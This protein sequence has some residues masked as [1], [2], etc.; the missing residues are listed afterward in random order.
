MDSMERRDQ[1]IAMLQSAQGAITGTELSQRCGVSRQVI[2]G[3]IAILRAQGQPIVSTPRGYQ[4]AGAASSGIQR[5]FVC[6]HG[7][8]QMRAELE[9]IV[10]NGGIVRNVVIEHEIY[11]NLEGTLNLHSRRDVQQFICKIENSPDDLLSSISGGI[12]T[13]LV[14]AA[15]EEEM[16]AIAEALKEAGVLYT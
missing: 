13:H 4:L 12:H 2:V 14:E 5:V 3:D 11:G 15:S 9:A 8:E 10:D 6:C 16:D 1:L 7:M